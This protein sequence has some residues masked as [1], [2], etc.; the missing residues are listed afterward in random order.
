MDNRGYNNN[1]SASQGW[2]HPQARPA[3]PVQERNP[4][5]AQEDEN[6]FRNWQQQRQQAAPS[7]PG[8]P[9]TTPGSAS[10]RKI[11]T[12]ELNIPIW[13]IVRRLPVSNP[14]TGN[15]LLSRDRLLGNR[16]VEP[17][18]VCLCRSVSYSSAI[19]KDLAGRASDSLNLPDDA[20]LDDVL[21]HYEPAIPPKLMASPRHLCEP[22]IRRNRCPAEAKA[23][24]S[25][26]LPPVSGGC[27][28]IEREAH[29]MPRMRPLSAGRLTRL[30]S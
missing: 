18:A 14:E 23:M 1:G 9:G 2:S 21:S 13:L 25:H 20:T 15:S 6:K 11:R 3:P 5:Q 19:L 8:S 12:K 22:G 26:C 29:G 7:E 17:G 16:E 10:P 27:A 30:L 28:E 4:A 24:R